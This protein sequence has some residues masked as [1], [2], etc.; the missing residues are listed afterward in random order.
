MQPQFPD[1]NKSVNRLKVFSGRIADWFVKFRFAADWPKRVV[2]AVGLLGIVTSGYLGS[3]HNFGFGLLGNIAAGILLGGVVFLLGSGAAWLVLWFLS[4]FPKI[5]IA[6]LIAGM[7]IQIVLWGE[8]LWLNWAIATASVVVMMMM[9]AGI[10]EFS[11]GGWKKAFLP[12]KILMICLIILGGGFLIGMTILLVLPGME[13]SPLLYEAFEGTS[14]INATDPSLPGGFEVATLTYGSGKDLRRPEFGKDVDIL[15]DTVNGSSFVS[16]SGWLAETR[17]WYWGFGPEALPLNGRVWY[18]QAEGKFPLV[19]IVHGNHTMTEFSDA[20]YAYIGDLLARRG[21]IVVSVDENFLNGGVWGEVKS[22]TDGR[23][24]LL[25]EHLNLWREWSQDEESPFFGIVD[26]TNI[27]LVGHSRGGEA[28]AIAAV[29][30]RLSR[31]PDNARTRWNY[32]FDIQAIVAIAPVDQQ[33]KPADHL[34]TLA[35]INYLLIQ[36]SH[37]SDIYYFQGAEQ[38]QRIEFSN[39]EDDWFKA[40]VYI[41]RANHGQFNSIWGNKDFKGIPGVLINRKAL[42][43]EA[44]Q[45]K[46]LLVYLSA[47]LETTLK[48]GGAYLP[49][50]MDHRSVGDWLPNTGY[51]TQYEDAGCV[52]FADYEEDVDVTTISLP[53]GSTDATGLST[54]REEALPFRKNSLQDNHAVHLRWSN[55]TASYLVR[56]PEGYADQMQL[57]SDV[58]FVFSM[59]DGRSP[60]GLEYLLD[61]SIILEDV[62]GEKASVTLSD[63]MPLMSQFPAQIYR[64]ALW[65]ESKMNTLS[66]PVLQSFRIPMAAFMDDNPRF[67]PDRIVEIGFHFDQVNEGDIWLDNLG[68]DLTP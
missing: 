7:I 22:E 8:W 17:E 34:L 38:F 58:S 66:E 42:L 52:F 36:G 61:L 23:A 15:T 10:S 55:K 21:Y 63:I 49:L 39:P 12:K 65:N 68:F 9:A 67:E 33:Y 48:G 40:S 18:P 28:V 60:K 20:G 3:E 43:P 44:E 29:F 59:A 46:I 25:L 35:D 41:Y 51:I 64:L 16:Y 14:T 45:Q 11:S 26:M 13:A 32:H 37:D 4:K 27:A 6:V 5:V 53:G 54:W 50:F 31:N 57:S 2:V 1:K 30:N 56:L 47:F 24:W 62:R 19:M